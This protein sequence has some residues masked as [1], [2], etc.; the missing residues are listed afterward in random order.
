[1]KFELPLFPGFM[2]MERRKGRK[3]RGERE[4]RK[5]GKGGKKDGME[6][7]SFKVYQIVT[8]N[9]SSVKSERLREGEK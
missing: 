9:W 3:E 7:R 8:L 5:K 4:E 1:M 6:E 2:T